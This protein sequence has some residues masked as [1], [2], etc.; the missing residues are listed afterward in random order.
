MDKKKIIAEMLRH[1]ENDKLAAPYYINSETYKEPGKIIKPRPVE[2]YSAGEDI[3]IVSDLHIASG[4]NEAGVYPGTEN[5]FADDSFYRFTLYAERIKK[6][7][8]AI[9][10]INGDI[11]DFL[12]ITEYPGKI[13]KAGFTKKFKSLVHFKN[14]YRHSPPSQ[15]KVNYD[16]NEWSGELEKI[17]IY[18]SPSELKDSIS[19]KEKIYGLQ[20]D[21]YKSVYKLL[22][23]KLGHPV[24]IKALKEWIEKGNK[25]ILLK[26]NHDLELY[27]PEVRNYIRLI[28]AEEIAGADKDL[29]EV[30]K[31]TVL[32]N[33]YFFD[34]SLRIN[35]DLYIEHGHRYDKFTIVLDDALL[36]RNRSQLNIPF[37]SFFNRYLLNRVELFYPFLDNVRPSKNVLPM[38]I[39]ENFPLALTVLFKHIPFILRILATNFRYVKFMFNRVF[40][41]TLAVLSPVIIVVI[42]NPAFISD[43]IKVINKVSNLQGFMNFVFTQA[44]NLG[45]LI[46]PYFLARLVSWLQLEEPSSLNNY[47]KIISE[48]N[49]YKYIV[50]GHTHNPGEYLFENGCRFYNTGTWIPVIENSTAD[51]RE[52]KTYTF[53]HFTSDGREKLIPANES[54][55]VRWNDEAGRAD[56]QILIQRK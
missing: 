20:T 15:D 44:K 39:K 2:Y 14:L 4:R 52:D 56:P 23:I 26:G 43:S 25:L 54:L 28:I 42:I 31:N 3:F 55:L 48:N 1:C 37:G 30:L 49:D 40:W 6:S 19:G 12:R 18:K 9:L 5:F 34:D 11:F 8:K 50:M 51:L 33:I 16:F 47:A 53:L 36:K 10:I 45:L 22:K 17:G 21:N 13:K 46:L 24:F 27:W 41:F 32:R 29:E 7:D 35:K 38:L